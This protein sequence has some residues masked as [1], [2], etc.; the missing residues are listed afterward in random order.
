MWVRH[1]SHLR[2]F[3]PPSSNVLALSFK[4]ALPSVL[5][6]THFATT[7]SA[8]AHFAPALAPKQVG[9]KRCEVGVR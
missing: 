3:G 4:R 6:P 7:H 8:L 5:A 1:G 2:R 9:G